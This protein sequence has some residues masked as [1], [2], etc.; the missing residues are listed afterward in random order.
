MTISRDEVIQIA[1]K[2]RSGMSPEQINSFVMKSHV[3][4]D[5]QIKQA[6]LE[7]ESR[8]HNLQKIA[9]QNKRTLLEIKKLT[10]KLEEATDEFEKEALL[11]ELE[12]L[13]LDNTQYKR[14]RVAL[15][16]EFDTF[17]Q[18]V[19][20]LGMTPEEIE[21]RVDYDPEEE[22]KYWIAR[23]GKQS[24]LDLITG[25]RVGHGNL[26]SIAMLPEEDQLAALRVAVQY[27]GLLNVSV[28][29]M[30][31][32]LT[33]YL[34]QLDRSETIA[35]PTFHGIEDNLEVPLLNQL[36]EVKQIESKGKPKNTPLKLSYNPNV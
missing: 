2:W 7:I 25:G 1:E 35:L 29:K 6:L 21:S 5:R 15:E 12:D 27:S 22:R 28:K 4:K 14:K 23:L 3:T 34:E 31:E 26:D 36:K 20:E 16:N 32:Q 17:V 30:Q 8:W 10:K 11:I 13:D 9:I 18:Y 33:P 19:Q 24:A